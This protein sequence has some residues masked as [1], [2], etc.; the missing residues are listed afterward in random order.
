VDRP[1]YLDW[2]VASAALEGQLESGDLHLVKTIPSGM[3]LAV[4]DGLGHGAEAAAVARR[5]VE[6]LAA[7]SS[8]SV[9]VL[10]RQCHA[11]LRGSRGAVMSLATL[12]V[13]ED[14]MTWIG[15]GNVEGV[16]A[17]ANM[18]AS[19][20]ME[21]VVLRNGVVGLRLPTLNA[22]VVSIAPGDLLVFATDGIRHDFKRGLRSGP[23]PA[24]LAGRIL[25]DHRQE[26]DDALVLVAE[27]RGAG[28]RGGSS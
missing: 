28:D 5:A 11:A 9:I 18:R 26:H 17:R 22:A 21:S 24:D 15:V 14:T 20:P 27:Y 19:V 23:R 4:V 25:A 12:N 8:E 6:T 16:L 13:M 10:I 2:S 1:P 7:S 3:L